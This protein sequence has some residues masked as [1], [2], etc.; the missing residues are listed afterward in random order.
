MGTERRHVM[1]NPDG[2]WDVKKPD[3]DRAR[4]YH[5]TQS[6]AEPFTP[7]QTP[8]CFLNRVSQVQFLPGHRNWYWVSGHPGRGGTAHSGYA[9]PD[10][11]RQDAH[12]PI[13]K[14]H[15]V[16]QT[17]YTE[18]GTSATQSLSR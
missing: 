10:P 14:W 18:P 8:G 15:E 16:K 17:D 1:P 12:Q 2:G 4:S 5:P 13:G 11:A 7:P 6:D 9:H 3:A